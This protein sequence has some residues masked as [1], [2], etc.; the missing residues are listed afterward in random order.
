M[1]NWKQITITQD[2][3]NQIRDLFEKSIGP[4]SPAFVDFDDG[5]LLIVGFHLDPDDGHPSID[6]AMHG[7]DEEHV[8]TIHVRYEGE[9][10][11]T[12]EFADVRDFDT[13]SVEVIV[14]GED[15][16]DVVYSTVDCECVVEQGWAAF[17]AGMIDIEHYWYN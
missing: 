8:A 10:A 15:E 13:Y 3:A 5:I 17:S 2:H 4:V 9:L 12:W 14:E 1:K 7:F 16:S 6:V 11:G